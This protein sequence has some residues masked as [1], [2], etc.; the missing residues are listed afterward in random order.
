MAKKAQSVNSVRASRDG[1]EFHEAWTARKSLQLLLPTDNIVGIA[2]EGLHPADQATAA[3]ETVEIAD[4]TLYY[5]TRAT[6]KAADRVTIVQFKYS[7]SKKDRGF[8]A[9]DA[10]ETITKFA[11]TYLDLKRSHGDEVARKKLQFELIT[12]RPIDSALERAITNIANRIALSGAIKR[13]AEQFKVASG[14]DGEELVEFAGKCLFTGLAG[15]LT[16]TKRDLSRAIV[17][18]S[19]ASDAMAHTRL[20]ALRQMVRDKAGY[21]G[22]NRNVIS[23]I[24]VLATLHIPSADEL[25]PCPASLPQVGKVVEREQ[26]AEAIAL[27]PKLDKPLL[28]HAAG[29]AGKTVFL[30]SLAQS[31]SGHH[32]V[33]F[34]D[35]FGGGAYRAPEDS[36][37]LPKRGL[38]HIINT[39][40]CRGLCD[41]LLPDNDSVES[42]LRTVRRRLSQS[43]TSLATASA[44]RNIVLI[45]DAI[46]NAAE[47]AKDSKEEAFPTLLLKSFHYGG[48]VPG[49]KLIVSCRSHRKAISVGDVPHYDFPL[50]TFSLPETAHYLRDRLPNVT[51]AE[52][53]VAQARSGGNARILEHL[54]T[55]DRGL[56]DRL[57]IGKTIELDDLLSERIQKALATAETRGYKNTEIDAF[58]A[59]LAVLP[60]PVPIDEYASAYGM[61][62]S[63]IESFA[64]D[65]APLLERTNHGL[66]FRDEPTETLLRDKFGSD[67]KALQLVAGNLL[68]RQSSS[69]YAARALPGLLQKLDDGKRLFELAFDERFPDTITSAVGKRNIRYARLKA[70]VRHASNKRDYNKVV[71]LLVELSTIAASDQRGTAY[72]LDYPDLVI[73]AHD[74]D[75]T[76]RL[77]E[78][79]TAWPGTRHARLSIANA[80]SG[81]APEAYRHAVSADE[82]FYHSRQKAHKPGMNQ[83]GPERLDIAAIPFCLITQNRTEHAL[84]F[85]REWKDWYAYEVCEHL[86]GLMDQT[87]TSWRE[88]DVKG[89][90]RKTMGD[91]GVVAAALSFLELDEAAGSELIKKLSKACQR[92]TKLDMNDDFW[93]GRNYRL[94]DGLL[95]SSAMA[96][97]A[98]LSAEAATIFGCIPQVRPQI[99]DFSDQFSDRQRTFIFLSIA[100]LKAV[101]KGEFLK[102]IDILPQELHVICDPTSDGVSGI[103]FQ[104]ALKTCLECHVRSEQD[105]PKRDQKTFTYESKQ[106]AE[107]FINDRLDPLLS[108]TRAFASVLGAP[109]HK[110]DRAF[111]DLL[112]AWSTAREKRDPYS[113]H[114]INYFF[115]SLGRQFVVFALWARGDLGVKSVE[116]F[117]DRLLKQ[118]MVSAPTCIEV[119]SIL[120]KRRTLHALAGKLALKAR[121]LIENEDDVSSRSSLYGQL[122][123]AIL[124]ASREE[125]AAYFREGLEQMDA[126]GSGD[127]QFTNELLLFASSLRGDELT[128]QDFHTLTNICE[129]NMP[130]EEEKF[131]WFAFAK[132]L[133][134]TSGCRALAKLSRWDDRSKISLNYTLL[135]YMVALIEDDKI[136]P[137]DALALL[138]LSNPAEL[139]S[140]NTE[141]LAEVIDKKNYPNRGALVSELIRQFESN[142]PGSPMDRTVAALA[143]VA[144]RSLG[145][146]AET[147]TYLSAAHEHFARVR[148][149]RNEHLNYHGR[150]DPRSPQETLDADR[151]NRIKLKKLAAKTD[152]N[153]GASLGKAIT[154]L[155]EMHHIYDI[156]GTFFE[157]LRSKVSFTDRSHYITTISH[158]E[159]LDIYTK[160]KELKECKIIWEESAMSL[161]ATYESLAIPILQLHAGAFIGHGQLSG[162]QLKELYDLSGIS[163]TTLALE[164]VKVS[165]SSDSQTAASVWL[166]LASFVCDQ[167]DPGAGGSALKRLLNSNSSKLAS[168]VTD[169]QWQ[170][171]IYPA[172]DPIEIA[173][174]LVWRMLG[175][176]HASDRWRA[177]HSVRCFARFGKWDVVDALVARFTS[178]DARPFQAPELPFYYMHA[179]L[180]LLIAL[181]RIALDAPERISQY[182]AALVAIIH[183]QD[184]PHV[185]MRH[186]AAQAVLAC[187]NS[188]HLRVSAAKE[189]MIKDIN[190]S[191]FPRL[192]RKL[193]E[194]HYFYKDRPKG[195]PK[196]GAEFYLDYDFDKY[197]VHHLSD[198]F[199]RPGWDVRDRLSEEV[200]GF[201]P[202]AKSM[203]DKGGREE[204][205]S[206]RLAA[207]NSSYHTYG[208]QLAW[209]AMFLVAGRFLRLYP[210]TDDSYNDNPWQDWLNGY[211]LTRKDGLWLSD[212]LDRPALGVVVNLLEKGE[213][214]LAITGDKA[215]L[216]NLISFGSGA[217]KEIVVNAF[218][219]SLDNIT[220]GITSSLVSHNVCES[221]AKKLI[222][223]EPFFAWLPNYGESDDGSEYFHDRR[224]WGLPWVVCPERGGRLDEEDPL[225][226]IRAMHRPNFTKYINRTFSIKFNDPFRRIWKDSSGR[227]VARAEAWGCGNKYEDEKCPS[228]VRLV[229]SEEFLRGVLSRLDKDLLLLIKLRRY[230]ERTGSVDS[231]FSH[232][233]AVVQIKKNLELAY[234]KGAVNKI[235]E[236]H[237]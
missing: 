16:N 179:R 98:G 132:A 87:A 93:H 152:P 92:K 172:N 159:N 177:A 26:L 157:N 210:V 78:T 86:F 73:A 8:R 212:G 182:H 61:D 36:R 207:M 60:P 103:E 225:G 128:E 137:D 17:D 70:A 143:S 235:H 82:W 74:V 215:K 208:Q 187:I 174:G 140:C 134:R 32:E 106:R 200:H 209:H 75:A 38:I 224:D 231:K 189:K 133:S 122:A 124:A 5:G 139:W 173:S 170:A 31:L 107:R 116:E 66:M 49:V 11:A 233:I 108:L 48:A 102:E 27:V 65:L 229:C 112:D 80:L 123:R 130:G 234:H 144:E 183:D 64:A 6:F 156:K 9:S 158:L 163:M 111:R 77:F 52:L 54:A 222:E 217:G 4:I 40:A 20:G 69:V 46:D 81:D 206:H 160:L 150:P 51:E 176:P 219:T 205:G 190:V 223:E 181:A 125:A 22:T 196:P 161:P 227:K 154:E 149:E 7:V 204:G 28:V 151:Q 171:G 105:Q 95:K 118:D 24:D 109:I 236:S 58:L 178:K 216:M 12:N 120:A 155:K 3:S 138:R 15:S 135:P 180:W 142:N 199:G 110:G 145:N 104:K 129:L 57:E 99:W 101:V 85:M 83:A 201:D 192:G 136:S 62:I 168:N 191:P 121:S 14:L 126:I 146:E 184:S 34:F 115:H 55:S 203:Y 100:A 71:R 167:A 50:K 59:G 185:L 175:S 218:W 232:T 39:L 188:G 37:H 68:D 131:P 33:L 165:A 25:L 197:D 56:L 90:L 42:L 117:L 162:Y 76:R 45:I 23:H 164:L 169:G 198:V 53:Q 226:S 213:R 221:L 97:A 63:A 10:K 47:H 166:G 141:T 119:I 21:A 96:V 35:C 237:K 13:Q 18:W 79:R 67:D 41:P 43:V 194:G 113:S 193:N 29:G 1:H 88:W 19:A 230:E 228:G 2:V 91:V 89:F 202:E 94:Q 153:D 214:N 30:D 127:Y 220:V 44:E 72:I 211:V 114:K 84:G 186:F 148:A 147:T 195:A